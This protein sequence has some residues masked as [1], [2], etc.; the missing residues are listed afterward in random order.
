MDNSVSFKNW[1]DLENFLNRFSDNFFYINDTITLT[2]GDF[3]K[4][5]DKKAALL[6]K[7]NHAIHSL[8][9]NLHTELEDILTLCAFIKNNF[10]ILP[11]SIK[12]AKLIAEDITAIFKINKE[13]LPTNGGLLLKTSGTSGNPKFYYF[14]LKNI[15]NTAIVQSQSLGINTNDYIGL[16]LPLFHVSGLMQVMR[17]LVSGATLYQKKDYLQSA[18]HLSF[19]P[20]QITRLLNEN[21][22]SES[23]IQQTFL[24]GGSKLESSVRKQ[25]EKMQY[26]VKES[27]GATETL[28][29]FVLNDEIIPPT[30]VTQNLNNEPIIFNKQLPEFY[31]QNGELVLTNHA[32]QG[33]TLKDIVEIN[34]NQTTKTLRFIERS[35]IVF[36]VAGENINPAKIERILK[37]RIKISKII[38]I[39]YLP[40]PDPI[41]Q[42][43][44]VLL[45]LSIEDL[46]KDQQIIIQQ[47]ISA[48]FSESNNFPKLWFPQKI[49]FKSTPIHFEQKI[50]RNSYI[51]LLDDEF[52]GQPLQENTNVV[53]LHGFLGSPEEM[54]KLIT[55]CNLQLTIQSLELLKLN[56]IDSPEAKNTYSYFFYLKRFLKRCIQ[57]NDNLTLLG[58]SMGGRV[59]MRALCE[60]LNESPTLKNSKIKLILISSSLGLK[61]ENEKKIRYS[62]DLEL[63]KNFSNKE[64]FLTFWYQQELFGLQP[65]QQKRLEL[66]PSFL[67]RIVFHRELLHKQLELFSP[68]VFPVQ[69]ETIKSLI[70]AKNALRFPIH[71]ISGQNDLQYMKQFQSL[72][73]NHPNTFQH[74]IVPRAFHDPHRTH[75]SD[76]NEILKKIL[77]NP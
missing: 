29:F 75:P 22:L 56:D 11:T 47:Q 39:L 49:I 21:K 19:V 6:K 60:I 37:E 38:D 31:I 53:A 50:S 77:S 63:L 24:I 34:N 41:Y 58:Y 48:F 9:L 76:I 54:N 17:T 73:I 20:T 25:L 45:V 28:G 43:V 51:K 14:S 71:L 42:Q 30:T 23:K 64:D 40:F 4:S 62:K 32:Q 57:Q 26:I 70:N 2:Y 66:D 65:M 67:K 7:T 55:N 10:L 36:K 5:V 33:I 18:H 61:D 59:L 8:E 72:T 3:L 68:G 69:E 15:L 46:L 16:N 35:D 1:N 27:Y 44:P 52:L 74:H 12:E 13:I